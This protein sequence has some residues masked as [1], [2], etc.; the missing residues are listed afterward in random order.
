LYTNSVCCRDVG[1]ITTWLSNHWSL[2]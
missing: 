1:T 2:Y